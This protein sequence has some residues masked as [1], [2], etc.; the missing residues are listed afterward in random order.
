M[1]RHAYPRCGRA[2]ALSEAAAVRDL[3]DHTSAFDRLDFTFTYRSAPVSLD[4]KEKRQSYSQS[5]R[6]LWPAVPDRDLFIIDE[7]VY[8]RVVWQGGGG[9]LA[10]HDLPSHRWVIFGPWELTLGR[11]VRYGRC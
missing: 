5:V 9:C 10:I 1:S 11:P 7:T 6:E 2:H 8:R 3:V 4:V